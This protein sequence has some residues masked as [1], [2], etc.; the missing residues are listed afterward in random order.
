MELTVAKE[1][2]CEMLCLDLCF[3]GGII[4]DVTKL[5]QLSKL[6]LLPKMLLQR[7]LTWCVAQ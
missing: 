1:S 7:V 2:V 4:R 6:M 3:S 5:V